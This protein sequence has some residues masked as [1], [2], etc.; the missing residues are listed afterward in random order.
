MKKRLEIQQEEFELTLSRHQA[1]L[2][3]IIN[4]KRALQE[5][6]EKVLKE[7]KVT[8]EKYQGQIKSLQEKHLDEI[9]R[10]RKVQENAEKNKKQQWVGQKTQEIRVRNPLIITIT[11][12]MIIG[13]PL[14]VSFKN[15]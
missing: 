6:C 3:Q 8:E 12:L 11:H 9:K 15:F 10:L 14:C 5:K 2:D 7:S 13:F 4:E 1:F